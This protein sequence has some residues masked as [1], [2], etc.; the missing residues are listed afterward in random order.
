MTKFNTYKG[1]LYTHTHKIDQDVPCANDN[2]THYKWW[3]SLI[4]SSSKGAG[5]QKGCEE[6]DGAC[7]LKETGVGKAELSNWCGGGGGVNTK[8]FFWPYICDAHAEN[9]KYTAIYVI[10]VKNLYVLVCSICVNCVC[11]E[12][13]MVLIPILYQPNVRRYRIWYLML[14]VFMQRN[15]IYDDQSTP[16]PT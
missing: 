13:N 15:Y 6:A 5:G 8:V 12:C 1:F 16:Q 11:I 3:V 14:I 10:F 7:A 2:S 9:R 4:E